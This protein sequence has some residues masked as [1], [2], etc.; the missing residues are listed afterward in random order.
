MPSRRPGLPAATGI[1]P[2]ATRVLAFAFVIALVLIWLA[3]N[4]QHLGG[5]AR[6]AIDPVCGMQVARANAPAQTSYGRQQF[7]FCSDRCR[8]RF[9]EQP[10]RH[11]AAAQ[12][13][14]AHARH[15]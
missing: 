10:E 5:G 11:G 2:D 9:A 8:E 6:Y 15:R 3:H 7:Y 13:H 14:G 4:Q 12:A 1:R